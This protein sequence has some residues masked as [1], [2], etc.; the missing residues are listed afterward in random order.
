[1]RARSAKR[2]EKWP[3]LRRKVVYR[4]HQGNEESPVTQDLAVS[5]GS[6]ARKVTQGNEEAKANEGCPVNQ[7]V[8]GNAV[9][10]DPKAYPV[11]WGQPGLRAPLDLAAIQV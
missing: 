6:P 10:L 3:Y 4:D 1:M 9:R 2:E 8:E 11:I 7:E 5:K